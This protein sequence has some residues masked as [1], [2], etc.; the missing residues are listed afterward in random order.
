[1]VLKQTQDLKWTKKTFG[2]KNL[3]NP[4]Q[5]I[6]CH[7]FMKL[8]FSVVYIGHFIT[9]MYWEKSM[10]N[11][12]IKYFFPNS[13]HKKDKY[14]THTCHATKV[15]IYRII[16]DCSGHTG[17]STLMLRACYSSW[18]RLF[19]LLD[20]FEGETCGW[21]YVA[22]FGNMPVTCNPKINYLIL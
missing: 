10:T 7:K 18:R 20:I 17:S 9:S 3:S 4:Q 15:I 2:L 16:V 21:L 11:V 6:K 1:V 12:K 5:W 13:F 19:L 8:L 22:Q 14:T